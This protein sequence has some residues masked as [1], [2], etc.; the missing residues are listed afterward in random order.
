MVK[1]SMLKRVLI[2]GGSGY[3]GSRLCLYLADMGYE[4]TPICYPE[5]PK[6]EVWCS[7]MQE[8]LLGD[9]RDVAFLE[10]IAK[11]SYDV[12]V[13]LVSLDHRDS[14]GLPSFVA[15]V[16]ITPTWSLLDVFSKNG[17]KKFVYFST[18]QVYGK[19]SNEK[20]TEA[21]DSEVLNA[22]GLTHLIG[23]QICDFYNR[24][25]SIDCRVVR[26]SN[27]YGA[28][29]FVE[30]NCWWLVINDLCKQAYSER[31]IVLQSDGTP[32]RDF[33]HG[34][35]VCQAVEKIIATEDTN[36]LYHISSGKTMT[37]GELADSIK[38]IYSLRYG[39]DI[40]VERAEGKSGVPSERYTIDNSN[41][42][43]IGYK[44]RWDLE[45]GVNDLFDFLE[46][47]DKA[48]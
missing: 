23:E 25:K 24:T 14:E 31:K 9:I 36:F 28:P 3:I 30:N 35:D 45:Q 26:L 10:E 29:I 13:H 21:N 37:I 12:I 5:V 7:K 47:N 40:L 38:S 4:V 42:L 22:Y 16:N 1:L 34:W 39:R 27:S 2:T 15:D 48:K 8:V 18:V 43:K 17:L 44:A 19:L 11:N 32:L 20:I 33:I 41:L 6:D 46:G